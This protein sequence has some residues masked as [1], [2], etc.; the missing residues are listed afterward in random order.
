MNAVFDPQRPESWVH[1]F[2]RSMPETYTRLFDEE[3]VRNHAGIVARR[4]P[5]RIHIEVWRRHPD[6]LT[7]LCVVAPDQPGLLSAV[8]TGLAKQHLSIESAQ[9]YTRQV[10]S[11]L[12]EAVDFFWVKSRPGAAPVDG[13]T[14]SEVLRSIS[15][16]L[17]A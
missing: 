1:D 5:N 15:D 3:A 12:D 2:V 11:S 17:T 9:V 13:E 7:V 4:G 6:G 8:V 16:K 10:S 14:L